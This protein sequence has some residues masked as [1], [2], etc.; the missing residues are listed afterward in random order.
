MI[1]L[2]CLL[3]FS[4]LLLFGLLPFHSHRWFHGGKWKKNSQQH[5]HLVEMPCAYACFN[6]LLLMGIKTETLQNIWV[7]GKLRAHLKRHD[8]SSLHE[9]NRKIF[10]NRYLEWRVSKQKKRK[11][12][13]IVFLMGKSNIFNCSSK[14]HSPSTSEGGRGRK[15]THASVSM[16]A[17]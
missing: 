15:P 12:K 16:C 7:M 17:S 5:F 3:A 10:L 9:E 11:L 13:F 14:M 8:F 2:S 6:P 4:H 1:N